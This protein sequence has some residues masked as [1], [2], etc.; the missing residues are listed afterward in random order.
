[1]SE[2]RR[3]VIGMTGASG[4]AYG[5]RALELLAAESNVETHLVV[6]AAARI[7]VG[8]ETGWSVDEV[9][10][11]ADVVHPIRDIS[12]GPASGSFPASGMLIAP[13]SIR[14]LSAIAHSHSADLLTRT[15]DVTLKERRPLVLMVRET[16]LH[17]GHLR[18]MAA[19]T[20]IGGVIFPPVPAFYE[21]PADLEALVTGTAARA[22][23]QLGIEVP[24]LGR[25]EGP[26]GSPA[27]G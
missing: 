16:P 15:A 26:V 2:S 8:L 5:I 1:M 23:A 27:P 14:A 12:A 18:L 3:I 24:G 9:E 19:V 10:A 20:E 22:L 6:T 11:L 4:V 25:W 13:C 17:L 21:Q 7:T